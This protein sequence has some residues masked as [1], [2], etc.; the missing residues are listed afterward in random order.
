MQQMR[1]RMVGAQLSPPLTINS[2]LDSVADPQ[3]PMRDSA[4]MDE[5]IAGLA[6]CVRHGELAATGREDRPGIADLTSGLTV[7]RGLV[8]DDADFVAALRFDY[9]FL[10]F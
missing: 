3:H 6:Q 8:D 1:H 4:E 2:E 9:P 5:H 7:K 10:A